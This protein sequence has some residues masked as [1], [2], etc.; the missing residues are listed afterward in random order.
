MFLYLGVESWLL[1]HPRHQG[2]LS[3]LPSTPYTNFRRRP[4]HFHPHFHNYYRHKHCFKGTMSRLM[5]YH[6]LL[7]CY[8][9][10]LLSFNRS[11]KMLK[12]AKAKKYQLKR[13]KITFGSFKISPEWQLWFL[14]ILS[15]NQFWWITIH[16]HPCSR[17]FCTPSQNSCSILFCGIFLLILFMYL[18]TFGQIMWKL[19]YRNFHNQPWQ[20][21]INQMN[22][23][24]TFSDEF[25]G[26]ME[27]LHANQW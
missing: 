19:E 14:D 25:L 15:K 8:N 27:L 20:F 9:C 6:I 13:I 10:A 18:V 24:V 22:N 3:P 2:V 21:P 16:S 17:L 26:F 11:R 4:Y 7:A 23:F 12:V 1:S 5:K